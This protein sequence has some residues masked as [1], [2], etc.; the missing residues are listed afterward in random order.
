VK[1]AEIFNFAA[2]A[3]RVHLFDEPVLTGDFNGLAVLRILEAIREINPQI[4]FC[5]ASSSEMF[6][7]TNESPQSE[8]TPFYPRNPYGVAKLYG[9]WITVN[10][11]ETHSLFACSSILF[12]HES[13]RRGEEFVTRKITRAVARIKTGLQTEL[14]LGDLE[15]KRDWGYAPDYVRAMWQMLQA[16]AASD[17]V[18]ATG[19]AHSV[20]ELC[21]IAFSHAG[22]N[23]EQ[24]VIGQDPSNNRAPESIQLV[25]DS[26]KARKLLGW[27]PSV[28]FHE[29][30]CTMVDADLAALASRDTNSP[31]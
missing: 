11:R 14:R 28:S 4:R 12:N 25:G 24:F 20:R 3:S 19:V 30:I 10:Y 17:Y 2:R 9:H 21:Q 23:Y 5:Q 22:M 8:T 1:P 27:A 7:K 16:P 31:S 18:I 29:L 26:R 13:P 6:G 15:A